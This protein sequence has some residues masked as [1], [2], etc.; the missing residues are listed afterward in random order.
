A[1]PTRAVW[2]WRPAEQRS[3]RGSSA[4][5]RSERRQVVVAAWLLHRGFVWQCNRDPRHLGIDLGL[6]I[7]VPLAPLCLSPPDPGEPYGPPEI[8]GREFVVDRR[9]PVHREAFGAAGL[10]VVNGVVELWHLPDRD[11]HAF[12]REAVLPL[13]L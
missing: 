9:A 11:Q 4:S 2:L 13:G 12:D 6:D 10:E 5:P 1:P 3:L 8:G 7:P